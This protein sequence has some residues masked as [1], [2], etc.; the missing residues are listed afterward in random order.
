ML[1]KITA[2]Q[3]AMQFIL[4]RWSY[5][6]DEPVIPEQAVIERDF[7]W[8]FHFQSRRALEG[9]KSR[10]LIGNGAIIVN[11]EDGSIRQ[12]GTGS[13]TE[14]YLTKYASMTDDER[15]APGLLL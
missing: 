1:D 6:D 8:V 14:Y 3:Q 9:D 11:R 15:R 12:C 4:A 5:S 2:Q 7:G 10:R 13:T